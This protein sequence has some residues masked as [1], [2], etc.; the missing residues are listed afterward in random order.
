M[1]DWTSRLLREA[2]YREDGEVSIE[3]GVITVMIALGIIGSLELIPPALDAIFNSVG[4][5]L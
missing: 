3:Y 4:D 2:R 1:Q 5:W